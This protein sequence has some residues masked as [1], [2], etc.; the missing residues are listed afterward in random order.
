MKNIT[1][2]LILIG[3]LSISVKAQQNDP[4]TSVQV[5]ANPKNGEI[6]LR[7]APASSRVWT[8]G[9]R[10]GYLIERY[11][12]L[13]DGK[14]LTQPEAR[15]ITQLP[16]KPEPLE[17]WQDIVEDNRY[18]AIAAQALYG[19]T[20]QVTGN[21]GDD[22][23][24]VVAKA[25][26]QEQRFSFALLAADLSPDV[27]R[28]SGLMWVDKD[29]S[30]NEKYLYK[31]WVDQSAKNDLDSGFVFVGLDDE[32]EL[33]A[34]KEFSVQ[35]SDQQALLTWNRKFYEQTYV[36]YLVE[37][38]TDE[39]KSFISITGTDPIINTERPDGTFSRMMFKLDSL[40]DNE[41]IVTYRVKGITPFG[42]TGPPSEEV[43]GNGKVLLSTIPVIDTAR[44]IDN[45]KVQLEWHYH[46]A[47]PDEVKS[48]SIERSDRANAPYRSLAVDLPASA[49]T[50]TDGQPL[51]TGYYRIVAKGATEEA[52]A[53]SFPQLVQLIDSIPPA[54]PSGLTGM[55]DSLGIVS[56]SWKPNTEEDLRGYRIFRTNFGGQEYGQITVNPVMTTHY[57]DTINVRTLT[58]TIYYKI[59][60]VDHH[61]NPSSFSEPVRLMRPDIL[62]PVSP[63]I[64][65]IK[66]ID[67]G[68]QLEWTNSSSADVQNH[69]LYRRSAQDDNW[70]LMAVFPASVSDPAESYTDADITDRNVYEYTLIA[71][72]D[73]Q[74]ESE[75]VDPVRITVN[76]FGNLPAVDRLFGKVDR[77]NRQI[78]ISWLFDDP[79]VEK[80]MVYRQ[81]E[82]EK[83]RLYETLDP[84]AREFQDRNVRLNTLYQYMVK[85]AFRNGAH[86][87][88]SRSISLRY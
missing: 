17:N 54:A 53:Y 12:I 62:P 43:A 29:V 40:A 51:S 80:F 86:S 61:H 73:V 34:P 3:F 85:V 70:R 30:T 9:N 21:Y 60:A 76:N 79:A 50:F 27:A 39:G 77:E 88:F 58:S 33:P 56:L 24:Q 25:K 35:F 31:V 71:V 6:T 68:V 37:K 18:G 19:E 66:L 45:R 8:R 22:I 69:L 38:S 41:T 36:G 57:T 75:P 64:T 2:I 82:G 83:F 65:G 48:F 67:E 84:A 11:T 32:Q 49:N 7:W 42:E 26:E 5:I 16:V 23:M 87:S 81:A 1:H 74:L 59:I 78:R 4:L 47:R 46:G 44:V 10:N 14:R 55:V 20:F 52:V 72:D 13:R 63:T 15:T 28:R